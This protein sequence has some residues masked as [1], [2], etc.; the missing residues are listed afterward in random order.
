MERFQQEQ[1]ER[2]Y[3]A[4][5]PRQRI[6]TARAQEAYTP[7]VEMESVRSHLS[8][9]DISDPEDVDP[10]IRGKKSKDVQWWPPQKRCGMVV[11]FLNVFVCQR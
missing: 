6:K 2:A 9:S 4:I 1:R 3:Q 10:M 7:D 8:R 11:E 5:Y